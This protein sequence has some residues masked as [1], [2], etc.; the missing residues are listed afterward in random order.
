MFLRLGKAISRYWWLTI[1]I[2]LGIVVSLR[3]V[4]P[5]WDD[6]TRDGDLAFLPRGMPSAIGERLQLAAFPENRA[7]SQIVL[8]LSREGESLTHADLKI[9]DR[10]ASRFHN[11]L[12][13]RMAASAETLPAALEQLDEA[14][15]TDPE[16][17]EAIHN[18]AIVRARLKQLDGARA[19]RDI[20]WKLTPSLRSAPDTFVPPIDVQL[21]LVDVWT[22][23]NEVVGSKL[24]SVDKQAQL[25]I[26][27]LDTEFMAVENM[28]A[29]DLVKQ[30]ATSMRA[31]IQQE[32]PRGLK[33]HLSGS[34]AI[35]GDM[36]QSASESIKST[37]IVTTL[38]VI[39]ILLLVYRAPLIVLVPLVTIGVSLSVSI[40][41]LSMI[42]EF[43]GTP[44]FEW[45]TFKVFKT[46]KI[47]IVVIL[48]GAGTDFCLFLIARFRECLEEGVAHATAIP[49][50]LSGVGNA[51]TASALTTIVGLG[52][53]FFA[54]FGKFKSSGPA[55]GLCLLVTL[56]A[57]LTL[58]PALLRALGP[59]VFW[60]FHPQP[61]DGTTRPAR[62]R[63]FSVFWHRLA[64]N[65]V[66]HPG[67]ILAG[68]V[69]LLAPLAYYG[70]FSAD[71]TTFDLLSSL[72]HSRESYQGSVVLKQ[73]F[74][75]GEG[76]PIIILAQKRDA[77]FD[78]EDRRTAAVAMGAIFDL[79]AA[80]TDIEG[81]DAVRSLAEPLGDPPRWSLTQTKKNILRQHRLTRSI[82][83]AQSAEHQ[84]NVTRFELILRH[85]PFSSGAID[86]LVRVEAFLNEQTAQPDQ[87]DSFWRDA[88]FAFAGTTAG[89]RDLRD[90]TRSD[91]WRIQI[92]VV[93]AVYLVLIVILRQPLVSLYLILSVLFSY[94]ITIGATELFFM[95]QYGDTFQG[96]D[97]KVPIFLFVILV[98]VGEDYNIYLVTRITE[99]QKLRGPFAGLREGVIRTGG[100]ITSCGVIMAGTFVSMTTGTLRGVVELGFALSLGVLLDT[101]IVRTILVPAFLAL[102]LRA[103]AARSNRT[104]TAAP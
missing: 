100:I 14:I 63:R 64:R 72:E 5:S 78:S 22:R 49:Q 54:D 31:E 6:I 37:E 103:K 98:A 85:D 52:M 83:L 94:L 4:A 15:R 29:L 99:E 28:A 58:A 65:I 34:A 44:G 48:F 61:A 68:C 97:W 88:K 41:L 33:L 50:S 35:G 81:V 16:N 45:W 47:F 30:E 71:H 3:L 76:S 102:M 17:A 20:A 39:A 62:R 7:Q 11:Y 1:L 73:H 66:V 56:F 79:T 96:L 55:I 53:M 10:L 70:S 104:K 95:W 19:D 38:L 82:F 24:R 101:F 74:P 46:T 25:I 42:A 91:R 43:A 92:L 90:V 77:G 59:A 21:P 75:I 67:K 2:W 12:A 51:L 32:D 93:L 60:P 84:G 13:V 87:P 23:H 80:L 26:L 40:N 86:T 18:R 89:I 57:C 27:Q 9:A 8:I 69:L 36:L